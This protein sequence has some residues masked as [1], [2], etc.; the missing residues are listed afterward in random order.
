MTTKKQLAG[1]PLLKLVLFGIVEK[2]AA[3]VVW[4][5]LHPDTRAA[6][7]RRLVDNQP[8][9][10]MHELLMASP[11]PLLNRRVVDYF[12]EK[13]PFYDSETWGEFTHA[14]LV[15]PGI[16]AYLTVAGDDSPGRD[17][18]DFP[19]EGHRILMRHDPD[20]G[21]NDADGWYFYDIG[22]DLILNR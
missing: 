19:V 7:I 2:G 17:D 16:E 22:R 14:D 1:I 18:P 15:A 3:G 4:H 21:D 9:A 6:L 5:H 11:G 8:D 12:R 13:L 20:L 10:E